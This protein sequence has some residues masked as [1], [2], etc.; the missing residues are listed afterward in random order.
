MRDIAVRLDKGCFSKSTARCLES[1]GASYLLKV[2]RYGWLG[3]FRGAWETAAADG[4]GHRELR[5]ASGEL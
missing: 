1:L 2:P 5:T 3:G 4:A